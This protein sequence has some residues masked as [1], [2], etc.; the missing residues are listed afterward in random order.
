MGEF[1][2]VCS[3][4]SPIERGREPSEVLASP[5]V[6]ADAF[7]HPHFLTGVDIDLLEVSN[8]W[9]EASFVP[10][11]PAPDRIPDSLRL[12]GHAISKLDTC[13]QSCGR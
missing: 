5:E 11:R 13:E 7:G 12:R 9:G 2:R 4:P 6:F 10:G 8:G 3:S 1:P